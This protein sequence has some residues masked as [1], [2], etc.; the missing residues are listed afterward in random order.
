MMRGT[1]QG[2]LRHLLKTAAP[3]KLTCCRCCLNMSTSTST[4]KL[5]HTFLKRLAPRFFVRLASI[6][7]TGTAL[8]ICTAHLQTADAQTVLRSNGGVVH[9]D[10]VG[11][12]LTT[13]YLIIGA[14][15]AATT[16]LR[17]IRTLHPDATCTVLVEDASSLRGADLER[18]ADATLVVGRKP[19]NLNVSARVVDLEQSGRGGI[20][21]I[22]FS[23][24]LFAQ[25]GVSLPPRNCVNF[26]RGC[27]E[28]SEFLVDCSRRPGA[29]A[30]NREKLIGKV[31]SGQLQHVTIIGGNWLGIQ[32]ACDL[33]AANKDVDVVLSCPDAGPLGT[34]VPKFVRNE[35][36]ARLLKTGILIK[37]YSLLAYVFAPDASRGSSSKPDRAAATPDVIQSLASLPG[38]LLETPDAFGAG[39]VVELHG[40]VHNPQYNGLT[41]KVVGPSYDDD[42]GLK[43][44]TIALDS[45]DSF[46][47]YSANLQLRRK[48]D[49]DAVAKAEPRRALKHGI[50]SNTAGPSRKVLCFC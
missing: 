24:C 28:E 21:K 5:P 36:K 35:I 41:G 6:A 31:R 7:A 50:G 11:R 44:F 33:K 15:L 13:D 30:Y 39:D 17:R 20:Q 8:A 32:L 23:A 49:R 3:N 37:P 48:A 18:F 9:S 46:D 40:L 45:G 42:D 38:E 1:A 27:K 47:I 26:G 10:E 25:G 12:M 22:R 29:G 34:Y 43:T 14:T 2:V 16:A 4:S 19:V